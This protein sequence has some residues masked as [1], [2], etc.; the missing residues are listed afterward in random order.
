VLPEPEPSSRSNFSST[1]S[2]VHHPGHRVAERDALIE[3]G[4]HAELDEAAQGG[5]ADE[6]T[7]ER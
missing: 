2:S 5:L 3:R 7:R 6:E 4:E 1:P